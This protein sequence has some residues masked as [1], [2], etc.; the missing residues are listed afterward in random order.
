[1]KNA[2]DYPVCLYFLSFW[3]ADGQKKLKP[4]LTLGLLPLPGSEAHL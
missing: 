4:H 1:M 3:H 2:E